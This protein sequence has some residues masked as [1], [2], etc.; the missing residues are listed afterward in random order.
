MT[1]EQLSNRILRM[2][3]ELSSSTDKCD[4]YIGPEIEIFV[5]E[6]E[7][8][9]SWYVGEEKH[10]RTSMIRTIT[11]RNKK[12]SSRSYDWDEINLI[13]KQIKDGRFTHKSVDDQSIRQ[14]GLLSYETESDIRSE[15]A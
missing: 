13:E 7:I 1:K 11:W 9:S 3:L 4:T 14:R 10:N 15:N 5:Y 2:G 6:Y 8:K 12:Y